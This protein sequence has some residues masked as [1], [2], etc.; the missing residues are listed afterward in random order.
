MRDLNPN[1]VGKPDDPKATRASTWRPRAKDEDII[2]NNDEGSPPVPVG[3]PG[4]REQG[5][6]SDG[7][8]GGQQVAP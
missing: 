1:T 5:S 3:Q 8:M 6:D 7:P 4:D 2:T